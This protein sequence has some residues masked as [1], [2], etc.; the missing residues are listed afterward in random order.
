MSVRAIRHEAAC[1]TACSAFSA[2]VVGLCCLVFEVR[3][4]QAA[5]YYVSTSPPGDDNAAGTL[6]A[7]WRTIA[8]AAQTAAA[9]DSVY[10]RAGTYFEALVPSNSGT[11]GAAITFSTYPGEKAILDGTGNA[12]AAQEEGLVTIKDRRFITV[13]GFTLQ[14]HTVQ[15]SRGVRIVRGDHIVV[16]N[17]IIRQIGSSGISAEN[18]VAHDAYLA[19]DEDLVI[20]GNELSETNTVLDQ[21]AI[22]VITTNNFVVR[23]NTIGLTYKEGIDAKVG[24]SHGRIYGNVIG[25]GDKTGNR[26]AIYIDAYYANTPIRDIEV[27]GNV[28]DGRSTGISLSGEV[29]GA[30]EDIKIY[31]NVAR[32]N[33]YVGIIVSSW[34]QTGPRRN[35]SIVNNT[36]HGSVAG[37]DVQEDTIRENIVVRNNIVSG[38][39]YSQL[40]MPSDV[41]VDHN[42]VHGPSEV[43]GTAPIAA[44]PLFKDAAHGDFHLQESS[45]A[46]D[47]GSAEGAP[48]VDF[49]GTPRPQGNGVDIGAF[50]FAIEAPDAGRPPD[51][52]SPGDGSSTVDS[53]SP[54]TDAPQ[55]DRGI[56]SDTAPDSA[57]SPDSLDTDGPTQPAVLPAEGGDEA[58]GCS[59]RFGDRRRPPGA[60]GLW[61]LLTLGLARRTRVRPAAN[62]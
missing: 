3:D 27:Y 12:A 25:P 31:N 20:E 36:V 35:I 2:A 59:C 8:H 1:P 28:I 48:A 57:V 46:R 7:P 19:G 52:A 43:Q 9:G 62:P 54:S 33:S 30:V 6:A 61:L 34:V 38:C 17:N 29:G 14:N 51:A 40:S 11:Q 60:W 56:L 32:N 41:T 16:R 18:V 22:S 15:Y 26:V 47:R 13:S 58:G 50:E 44:D 39:T 53:A 42:V 21:E 10:V 45:P 5:T 55:Q 37:I 23:N 4:A 49:D 24:S